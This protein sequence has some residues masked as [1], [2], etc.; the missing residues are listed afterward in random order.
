LTALKRSLSKA[1]KFTDRNNIPNRVEWYHLTT[2]ARPKAQEK[3]QLQMNEHQ[4]VLLKY[5]LVVKEGLLS[6]LQRQELEQQ[7]VQIIE[8]LQ[9]KEHQSVPLKHWLVERKSLL[10]HLQRQL[11]LLHTY[12]N[13]WKAEEE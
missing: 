12:Q 8:H 1:S 2:K 11:V 4:S 6:H 3:D 13:D 9:L 5:W 10:S 7:K